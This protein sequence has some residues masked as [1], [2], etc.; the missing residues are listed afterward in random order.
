[1]VQVVERVFAMLKVST[2]D[3][4]PERVNEI[5]LLVRENRGR[6]YSSTKKQQ[7]EIDLSLLL[8]SEQ[9]QVK[10]KIEQIKKGESST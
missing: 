5:I 1:M 9:Y 3:L 4:T 2:K 7:L 6:V 10:Q 8:L